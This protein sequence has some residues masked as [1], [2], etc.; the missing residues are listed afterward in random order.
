MSTRVYKPI[1]LTSSSFGV[2]GSALSE[3]KEDIHEYSSWQISELSDFSVLKK[4]NLYDRT[5]LTSYTFDPTGV[6]ELD[7]EHY[8]RVKYSGVTFGESDWSDVGTF[9]TSTTY[10]C[11][12]GEEVG[13]G[14][15]VNGFSNYCL[16]ATKF[17]GEPTGT[18]TYRQASSE[19]AQL[20]GSVLSGD[21]TYRTDLDVYYVN[22]NGNNTAISDWI[23]ITT[24][25]DVT[26]NYYVSNESSML[27]LSINRGEM[28]IRTDTNQCFINISDGN[29][30][31]TDWV[32]LDT[33]V[34]VWWLAKQYCL[35]LDYG[36]YTDWYMPESDEMDAINDNLIGI[37]ATDSTGNLVVEKY[38]SS[39]AVLFEESHYSWV[40]DMD[41]NEPI[42]KLRNNN[43]YYVRPV[44]RL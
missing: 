6:L 3:I 2:S 43:F 14:I 12:S 23:L 20:T 25:T 9:K 5:N 38:W 35:N 27:S 17:D 42:K 13:G 41:E 28:C 21:L 30:S 39:S 10:S 32:L 22:W 1:K 8:W 37:D 40:Q 16:V 19:V 33:P 31:L 24:Q 26:S 7:T 11:E 34:K 4:E 36:G 44:R 18:G 29:G 15:V